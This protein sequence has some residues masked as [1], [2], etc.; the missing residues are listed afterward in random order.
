MYVK[1]VTPHVAG[2]I[3]VVGPSRLN[4]SHVVPFV[5]YVGGLIGSLPVAGKN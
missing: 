1:F 4:Y 5:Q 3:G 2:A